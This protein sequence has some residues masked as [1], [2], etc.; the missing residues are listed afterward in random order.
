MDA[1]Q[2]KLAFIDK[3]LA[4]RDLHKRIIR[5]SPL[6]FVA[7]GL[8]AGILIQEAIFRSRAE[9]DGANVVWLW[10]IILALGAGSAV[11]I[12]VAQATGRVTSYAPLLLGFCAL[13]CFACLGATRAVSFN[14]PEANDIRNFVGGKKELATEGTETTEKKV[15]MDSLKSSPSGGG[16]DE[17]SGDDD[18]SVVSGDAAPTYDGS[19]PATIR[20]VIVTKPFI[21]RNPDWEFARFKPTDP[22]SSFYLKLTEAETMRGWAN[23]S[24]TVRVQ[25]EGPVLDLKAGDCIQAY[26]RLDRFRPTS[27]PGE[28]DTATSLARRGVFVAAS[29]KSREGIELFQAPPA[30]FTRIRGRIRETAGQALLGSLPPEEESRALMRAL[31]LGYRADIGS[32]TYRAFRITGLVHFLSLSGAH[33]AILI[34]IVWWLCKTVGLLKRG[35]AA[36]CIVAVALF[37]LVVPPAAPTVRAAIIAWVFCASL[38]FRRH[39]NPINAL[40]LAAI[41]L[42]LIRPTHLF[43]AGWQLSFGTVLGILLFAERSRYALDEAVDRLAEELDFRQFWRMAWVVRKSAAAVVPALSV[44]VGAWLGGAG[45][46]LYQFY[47]ITLLAS[48]WTVLTLPLVGAIMT[49]GFAKII[50]FFFLPTL[51]AALGVVATG[52]SDAFI[53]IVRLLARLDFSQILVGRVPLWLVIFYYCFILFAFFARF[54][55]PSAKSAICTIAGVT[56]MVVV[57]GM[58]WQRTHRGELILT[59]LDVSHGQA[60]IAGFPG[61]GNAMFDA[62]SLHKSDIGR[63]M[64]GPFLD[65]GGIGSIDAIFVSHNDIDHVNGIPEVVEWC[66]VG[67]VYANRAF[68][69]DAGQ[70]G[71]A[72]FLGDFL[73]WAGL[74][75][76]PV[77]PR[78]EFGGRAG[79]KSIW[80]SAQPPGAEQ[81]SDNDKSQVFLIE[82]AGRRILL[83]SDIEKFA[84]RE[85]LRQNPDLRADIVVVPHHGSTNTADPDFLKALEAKILI[86]SCGQTEYQ[87][88]HKGEPQ[89]DAIQR[90]FTPADGAVAVC[91]SEEGKIQIETAARRN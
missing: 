83:C 56:I 42:L 71:A 55:R 16:N 65:Y 59:C 87:R 23:V 11:L 57:G 63:R 74:K 77:T 41:I 52:L 44:G 4:G 84:Q 73:S 70:W 81:L 49:V 38:L 7:V 68:F 46:L 12:F 27:N 86:I 3:Q 28:F 82:F 89:E 8:I 18:N 36:L 69:E 78:L 1:I 37:L 31:L 61:G 75:I 54:R 39:S 43:D 66:K 22:T 85:I 6:V 76:E 91:I 53:G 40:S 5:T 32:D 51:S 62:G 30:I 33:F 19:M 90:L 24:G 80:P 17:S 67:R 29:V 25:V 2:R 72:K 34:G 88:Q 10:L 20:G 79:V 47:T 9:G 58:K 60:I 50:V 48:I 35:S 45:I 13:V 15:D 21:D 26:C 14:Q 64:V